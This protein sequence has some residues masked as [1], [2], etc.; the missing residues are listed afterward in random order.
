MH[1]DY[2]DA[3]DGSGEIAQPC[4]DVY[5]YPLMSEIFAKELI[6]EMENFGQW[7]DGKNEVCFFLFVSW[8][9]F[10]TCL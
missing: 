5:H 8:L 10:W 2:F 6:E 7:S 4:P 3:L 1:P 9:T